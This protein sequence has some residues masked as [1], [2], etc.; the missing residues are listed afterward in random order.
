MTALAVELRL[1]LPPVRDL[2]RFL[3]AQP[4]EVLY[5]VDALTGHH[6]KPGYYIRELFLPK[7]AMI[8]G[9]LHKTHNLFYLARGELSV[10]DGSTVSHLKGPFVGPVHPGDKRFGV[11]HTDCLMFNIH[12]NPDNET[13][14]VL[15]ESRYIAA[16][17][18]HDATPAIE[19]KSP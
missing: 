15:L 14:L 10:Y 2:E 4:V 16:E 8:V 7:G 3:K 11:A 17:L 13:D 9:K 5:D 1:T 12:A 19:D 18:E 6:F